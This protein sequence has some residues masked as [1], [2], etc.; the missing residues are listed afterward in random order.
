MIF[1]GKCPDT[2]FVNNK[3]WIYNEM[4]LTSDKWTVR[5]TPDRT[6]EAVTAIAEELG[7]LPATAQLLAQRGYPDPDSAKRFLN[8]GTEML[9]DP[10]M[11]KDMDKAARRILDA[12]G[13]GEKTVIYGDYDVDGVTSVS[14]LYLYLKSIGCDIGYYIPSRAGEGYGMSADRVRTLA[15]DGVKLIVTVD[16]GITA[17]GEAQVARECGI[18]LVITDHHE[19]HG[20]GPDAYAVVNPHRPDCTYPFRDLAGVGVVFKLLCAMEILRCPD[21]SVIDCIRRICSDY[22]DLVAIGTVADVMPVVDEN[23][24]IVAQGLAML[25]N[26]PRPAIREL[27]RAITADSKKS[28]T[29]HRMTSNFI[30]FT[31]A[32]RINAAGRVASASLAVD[33]FL[34][35][36]MTEASRLAAELCERNKDRQTEENRIVESAREKI[37]A[38]PDGATAPV[39]VLDDE[40]WHH[41]VIG[42]V[43]S[44]I[45]EKYQVPSILVSFEGSSGE[46]SPEDVGKGSG[47][48]VKGMNL[49]EALASCSDLLEKFGGHELAAGLSV[50]RKNL[51]ALRERLCE[52]ARTHIDTTD[53]SPTLEADAELFPEDITIRQADE[54]AYLEPFGVGNTA[55]VFIIRNAEIADVTSVGEGKHSKLTVKLNTQ[56]V[57]AMCF[58][59]T[60]EELDFYPGDRVDIAFA[61][62]VNEYMNVRSVQLLVREISPASAVLAKRKRDREMYENAVSAVREGK[63]PGIFMNRSDIAAVYTMIKTELKR[64][65]EVFSIHALLH[66]SRAYGIKTDYTRLRL[67]LDVLSELSLLGTELPKDEREIW[68][69]GLTQNETKTDLTYSPTFRALSGAN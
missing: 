11:M 14:S 51:P 49:V 31:I 1:P 50:K 3:D 55:P 58:R 69:F 6:S 64:R 41:G 4:T 38:S 20:D 16:T 59:C 44:R 60:L 8:K 28:N 61:L 57:T 56:N 52:Y 47:R 7:I 13:K 9:H 39:I 19:C 48:S 67:I 18:D 45:T 43:A 63:N 12:V 30:G 62:D 25:E 33:M 36:D 66:L 24:L 46:I 23:R 15:A 34:S 29:K 10:F 37:D 42:I 65:H 53:L 27:L 68:C 2:D 22:I 40:T 54:F 35:D 17:V 26:K 32:P 5:K 21:D